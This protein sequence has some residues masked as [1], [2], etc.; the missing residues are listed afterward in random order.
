MSALPAPPCSMISLKASKVGISLTILAV[1]SRVLNGKPDT[2][3]A[4]QPVDVGH[5]SDLDGF[6]D[7]ILLVDAHGINPDPSNLSPE[8]ERNHRCFECRFH[9]QDRSMYCIFLSLFIQRSGFLD[10]KR[11]A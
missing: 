9:V 11:H 4:C 6:L 5:I 7:I 8:T 10:L 3:R 1:C 2:D